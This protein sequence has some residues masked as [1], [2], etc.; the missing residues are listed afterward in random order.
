M[1]RFALAAASLIVLL[2]F[3]LLCDAGTITYSIQNYPSDQNQ[4]SL[5]GTITTD[6]TIGDLAASDIL[7]W[8]WTITPIGGAPYTLSSSD[9]GDTNVDGSLVAS[10]SEITMALP[11]WRR[12]ERF[13]NG[14]VHRGGRPGVQSRIRR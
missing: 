5:S 9:A 4:A 2:A 10:A 14:I 7:S 8:S 13:H 11:A 6:G 12:R 3:P 1:G